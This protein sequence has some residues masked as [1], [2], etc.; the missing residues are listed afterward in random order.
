MAQDVKVGREILPIPDQPHRGAVP[1]DARN[2]VAPT[3]A[4]LHAPKG[5]PNV[6]MVLVDDM[7]FGIPSAFGGCVNMPTTDRLAKDG[8]VTPSSTQ[9]R[10]V[11]RT[12]PPNIPTSLR[13]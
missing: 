6:V 12:W 3:Q 8:C 4:V 13:K 11:R 5:A 10:F 9:Q 1:F 7:G 2:A